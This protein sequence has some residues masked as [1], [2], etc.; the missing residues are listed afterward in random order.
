MSSTDNRGGRPAIGEPINVRLGDENLIWLDRR[1]TADGTTRAELVRSI[2]TSARE[3]TEQPTRMSPDGH[4]SFVVKHFGEHAPHKAASFQEARALWLA[5]LQ[6]GNKHLGEERTLRSQVADEADDRD[7]DEL[8]LWTPERLV[9]LTEI[10]GAASACYRK[11]EEQ[12]ER[13]ADC[14]RGI[15]DAARQ[16]GADVDAALAD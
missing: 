13:I 6:A 16:A 3:R 4:A 10:G 5:Y 1:A 8:E 11:Q 14:V 7:V 12:E 9:R 15:L 2:V